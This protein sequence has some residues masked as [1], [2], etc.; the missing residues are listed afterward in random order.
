MAT[1]Q[2]NNNNLNNL[3]FH[4]PEWA[5]SMVINA[6]Q[7]YNIPAAVLA[8]LIQQ[9]SGYNVRAVSP[10]GAQG[11]A[12]FMPGTAA[13]M[14]IDPMNPAQAIDGAAHY[15]RNA[16]DNFGGNIPLALAAYN[17]GSG[18]VAKYGGIP[19]FPETQNYV[20]NIM[21]MS[22]QSGAQPQQGGTQPAIPQ[23]QPSQQP[24]LNMAQARPGLSIPPTQISNPAAMSPQPNTGN[25]AG[26]TP[27]QPG[28][29]SQG[30]MPQAFKDQVTALFQ[31]AQ[32]ARQ[33][34][35][36]AVRASILG[37]TQTVRSTQRPKQQQQQQTQQPLTVDQI[38]ANANQ[39]APQL[40]APGQQIQTPTQSSVLPYMTGGNA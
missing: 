9:E 12:Q 32:Q 13:G 17:S 37:A 33:R 3:S 10:A 36:Q 26:V 19:P 38:I 30:Q 1:S 21:A 15:L 20:R 8:S 11:I 31:R 5:K 28:Q 14:H 16:M 24:A 2:G 4:V 6:A 22:G 34:A 35:D 18:N 7:K 29:Y 25:L 39:N 40:Q 23:M 27:S